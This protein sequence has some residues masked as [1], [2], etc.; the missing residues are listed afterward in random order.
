MVHG[1]IVEYKDSACDR[2]ERKEKRGK[3]GEDLQKSIFSQKK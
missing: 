2:R 1:H 3:N